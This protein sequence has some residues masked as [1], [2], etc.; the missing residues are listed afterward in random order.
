MST[1]KNV[2][3]VDLELQV[4]GRRFLAPAEGTF[5][6]ADEFDYQLVDQ[7]AFERAGK[8]S[9]PAASTETITA[10]DATIEGAN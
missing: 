4:D 6:V 2:S 9:A 7:P 10:P 3:G 5:D 1:F 8:K